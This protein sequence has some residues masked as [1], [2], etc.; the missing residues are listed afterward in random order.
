MT[1]FIVVKLKLYG[2]DKSSY[3]AIVRAMGMAR[4]GKDVSPSSDREKIGK[5]NRLRVTRS[6]G[7]SKPTKLV[8]TTII[9]R[10]WTEAAMQ[11]I[12]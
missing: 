3:R 11:Q 8:K 5:T 9:L 4:Q 10:S 7:D 1:D 12:G 2:D 6:K